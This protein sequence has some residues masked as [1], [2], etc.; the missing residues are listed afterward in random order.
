MARFRILALSLALALVALPLPAVSPPALH[1]SG[2]A[3]ATDEP[4]ATA[5]GVELLK[6]GGNAVD[7]AVGTAL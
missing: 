1:G 7:A 3:V 2:G 4:L 6:Q 5:V